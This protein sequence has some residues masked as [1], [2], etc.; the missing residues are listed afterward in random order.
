VAVGLGFS[1]LGWLGQ[2]LLA[3]MEHF[4]ELAVAAVQDVARP[5]AEELADKYKAA[6][7]GTDYS[8]MLR[9]PEVDAVVICTPNVQHPAQARAALAL[10]KHVLVQKP[11]AL[12]AREA[13]QTI[14]AATAAQKLLLVDCS[15]RFLATTGLLAKAVSELGP[16][17]EIRGAFH[18]TYGPGKSWFFDPAQ[19]GGGA[20]MD[21]G[22]HLIDLALH[23][24]NPQRVNLEKIALGYDRGLAVEDSALFEASLD[25]I[26][27][28]LEVSWQAP[29][30]LTDISLEIFCADGLAAWRNVHGSF[31]R[32]Q[33][34]RDD[35]LLLDRETTLRH[36]TFRA[37][38]NAL[39]DVNAARPDVRVYALLEQA[40]ASAPAQ[41]RQ[42]TQ[43]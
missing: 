28:H 38:S 11:L 34:Y 1:G 25:T 21:L 20:L 29:R 37:F 41:A 15:Y 13:A 23:L 27:L 31:F 2:S 32:F 14:D 19:S 10:G 30:D 16:I 40:Y 8:D 33:T 12:S 42:G 5:L 3:E 26:P 22:V 36:D 35:T 43:T 18:N 7:V 17:R 9:Q 24:A 39:H 6:W 4:P